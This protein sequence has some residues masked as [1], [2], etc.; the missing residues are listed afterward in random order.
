MNIRGLFFTGTDTE[1]GKTR[2]LT[3]V[4]RIL[5]RQGCN[6]RVCKPIASGA[7]CHQG[8]P[9]SP[10]TLALAKA[11]EVGDDLG[12]V[13]PWVFED[14]VAPSVAARKQG[15]RLDPQAVAAKIRGDTR[16]DQFLLVEGV[17]GLLC[18]VGERTTVADLACALE[19]PLVIVARRALGT[20]NHTLLTLEAARARRLAVAGIVVNETT[21]PHS[22]AEETNVEELRRQTDSPILAVVPYQGDGETGEIAALEKVAWESLASLTGKI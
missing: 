16:P 5:R 7:S 13:T 4:A 3:G 18:P 15:I 10:D 6:L 9:V 21:P 19:L 17:G 1:V 8:R 11:A 20:L 12:E 22:L 14:P 2:I